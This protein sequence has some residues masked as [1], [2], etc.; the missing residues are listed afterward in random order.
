MKKLLSLTC[1][2]LLALSLAACSGS[3]DETTQN[4]SQ[5]TT[6]SELPVSAVTTVTGDQVITNRLGK[7]YAVPESV[8]SIISTSASSTEIICG[9]GLGDKIIAADVYSSDVEGIDPA[10]CTLDMQNP[11]VE[12]MASLSPDVIFINGINTDGQNDPYAAL[13]E[14]GTNVVYI[15]SAA[16]ITDII[17]DIFFISTF[18]GKT[19]EGADMVAE[20]DEV[21]N[22]V[23]TAAES[24]SEKPMVYFELMQG[25]SL[26]TGTFIDEI[27]TLA[28]G[29]NV[30]YNE[31]DWI[32]VTDEAVVAANPDIII[33][34]QNWDGYDYTEILSRD[35]WDAIDAVKN[36]A[37]YQVDANATSRASQNVVEGIKEIAQIINPEYSAD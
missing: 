13:E 15:P 20:I 2:F 8:N 37:V 27:I 18:T 7:E 17:N 14:L 10:V 3:D 23:K 24:M 26:G 34:N 31:E 1:A 21:V 22:D 9:L 6:A 11:D 28:G 36:N 12:F 25:Y 29:I 32:T 33:T 35:G 19:S 4:S 30:F 16:S 5:T